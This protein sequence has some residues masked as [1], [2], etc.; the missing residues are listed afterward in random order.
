M[1]LFLTKHFQYAG[2]TLIELLIVASIIIVLSIIVL[3]NYEFGGYQFTLQRSTH[4]L[5]QDLRRVEEM[6]MSAREFDCG[7]LGI[8]V[9]PGGYGIYFNIS[10]ASTSYILFA[11]CDGDDSYDE[12]GDERIEEME[13]E[14]G[15][16]IASPAFLTINFVPPNPVVVVNQIDQTPG[17][18]VSI[19]LI[20][21]T[22]ST[23]ITVNSIGLIEIQ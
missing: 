19:T 7:L 1:K 13:L 17:S 11:D 16:K 20:G 21:K 14:E 4:K 12:I 6:A 9:P 18:S 22:Q 3:A 23:M 10:A 15:I 2:F 8:I 5:A